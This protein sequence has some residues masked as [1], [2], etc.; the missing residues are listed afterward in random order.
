MLNQN[1]ALENIEKSSVI[2]A[3]I[4][5]PFTFYLIVKDGFSNLKYSNEFSIGAVSFVMISLQF[6]QVSTL[7]GQARSLLITICII[8]WL[9]LSFICITSDKPDSSESKQQSERLK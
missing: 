9:L 6:I 2:F 1:K 5:V 3:Y 7:K 4:L 8:G